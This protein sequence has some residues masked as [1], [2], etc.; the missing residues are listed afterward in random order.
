MACSVQDGK[1]KSKTK[2]NNIKLK[3]QADVVNDWTK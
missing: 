1:T 2:I 3:K